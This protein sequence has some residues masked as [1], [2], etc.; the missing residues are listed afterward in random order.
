MARRIQYSVHRLESVDYESVI[1]KRLQ[2]CSSKLESDN[3]SIFYAASMFTSKRLILSLDMSSLLDISLTFFRTSSSLGTFRTCSSKNKIVRLLHIKYW[4]DYTT[5][6]HLR[7]LSANV[8]E[9]AGP[10]PYLLICL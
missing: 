6:L 8:I 4:L 7:T 2:Y 5:S 9:G 1:H 3:L 10:S